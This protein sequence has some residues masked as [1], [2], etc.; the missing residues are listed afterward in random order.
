MILPKILFIQARSMTPHIQGQES[1]NVHTQ[2]IGIYCLTRSKH[3]F[4]VTQMLYSLDIKII[5]QISSK[6]SGIIGL[7]VMVVHRKEYQNL[8]LVSTKMITNYLDSTTVKMEHLRLTQPLTQ[9]TIQVIVHNLKHVVN[10]QRRSSVHSTSW[11]SS[12]HLIHHPP[13]L[14]R[15]RDIS[16][17][18]RKI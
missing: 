12:S 10:L 6:V 11:G 17:H 13:T 15:L 18:S 9:D 1:I 2:Q 5:H 4:L 16:T 3:G 14:S 7:L 8:K